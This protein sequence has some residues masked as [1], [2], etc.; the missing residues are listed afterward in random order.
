MR[1]KTYSIT[2]G[3]CVANIKTIREKNGKP[4][5]LCARLR[6]P[7]FGRSFELTFNPKNNRLT[8]CR[9]WQLMQVVG[10]SRYEAIERAL[11]QFFGGISAT[12]TR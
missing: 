2:T 7:E 3:D 11:L 4:G 6:V 9:G 1:Q 12:L 5:C 10:E 8:I